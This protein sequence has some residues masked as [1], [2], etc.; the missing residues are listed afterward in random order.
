VRTVGAHHRVA[1]HLVAEKSEVTFLWVGR[2]SKPAESVGIPLV[3][4]DEAEGSGTGADATEVDG[5][6]TAMDEWPGGER[7]AVR[8]ARARAL[9]KLHEASGIL[10]AAGDVAGVRAVH[11]AM[12]VLLGAAEDGSG[13][14]AAGGE[15]ALVLGT[16]AERVRR[17]GCRRAAK[18]SAS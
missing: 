16:A 9:V 18:H 13:S 12:G 11:G 10:L 5:S 4:V 7:G 15:D 8:D 2:D 3:Y 1:R 6:A 14:A 17:A